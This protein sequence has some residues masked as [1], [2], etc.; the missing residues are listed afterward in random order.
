M[1]YPE[2][3]WAGR[4]QGK[5]LFLGWELSLNADE[6]QVSQRHDDMERKREYYH[7]IIFLKTTLKIKLPWEYI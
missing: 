2:D 7:I 3:V 5:F 6:Q 1:T 4:D